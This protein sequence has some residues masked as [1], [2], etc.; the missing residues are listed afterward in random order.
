MKESHEKCLEEF[1]EDCLA[2]SLDKFLEDFLDDFFSW[3]VYGGNGKVFRIVPAVISGGVLSRRSRE[4]PR[5][6]T[7]SICG[8]KTW[9][10]FRTRTRTWKKFRK[11]FLE[12][13]KEKILDDH[14][15]KN[16][17]NS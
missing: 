8:G 4:I 3:G 13:S 9:E 15:R 7:E 5:S 2:D 1:L 11:E 6:I 17:K 12:K 10:I 14:S 16:L